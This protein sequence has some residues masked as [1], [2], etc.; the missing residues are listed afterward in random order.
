MNHSSL[1]KLFWG[2][3]LLFFNIR[4]ANLEVFT[5][6]L[7][8]L[9]V[10]AA[11]WQLSRNNVCLM[12]AFV[13]SVAMSVF[14]VANLVLLCLRQGS[15]ITF[16]FTSGLTA[17]GDMNVALCMSLLGSAG[18]LVLFYNLFHGLGQIA[19]L[20]GNAVMANKLYFC[21][22]AYLV[23]E[24][25]I[26]F[27][28]IIPVLVLIALVALFAF[29]IYILV[30]VYRFGIA[31]NDDEALLERK[32]GRRFYGALGGSILLAVGACITALFFMNAPP[33]SS[34]PYTLSTS[35]NSKTAALRKTLQKLGFN[36]KILADLPD[37]EVLHYK[38]AQS[39]K[40]SNYTVGTD[41]GGKL[42]M[43]QCFTQFTAG[44]VRLLDYYKWEKL[45]SN[46]YCDLFYMDMNSQLISV[47]PDSDLEGFAL[48]DTKTTAGTKTN[49][50]NFLKLQETTLTGNMAP[51][52]K[53]RLLGSGALHQR[54]FIGYFAQI[55][56]DRYE[57]TAEVIADYS[58]ETSLL[59]FDDSTQQVSAPGY[60]FYTVQDTDG[61]LRFQITF[62]VQYIP[63][64]KK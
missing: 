31:E 44:K 48:Y 18:M 42:C 60:Q 46:R 28:L 52:A 61:I 34:Q 35:V 43:T 56:E 15:E 39:V 32:I 12:R 20:R 55:P 27:M 24:L 9:L 53:Y 37:S 50:V 49:K 5:T 38:G 11:T 23:V 62:D 6:S 25:L 64:P 40:S 22:Y 26:F 21:F 8:I 47:L 10:T 16:S 58:H 59:N 30:Q 1:S 19:K 2:L 14:K 54:G 57:S 33:V 29:F 17:T 7:G 45:P 63:K 13:L 36:K 41:D 3:L 51:M 4:I